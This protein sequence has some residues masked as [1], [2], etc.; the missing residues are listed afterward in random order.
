[1]TCP[2]LDQHGE[3]LDAPIPVAETVPPVIKDIEN[4]RQRLGT[5]GRDRAEIPAAIRRLVFM[6]D[7]FTCQWCG[8]RH[9]LNLRQWQRVLAEPDAEGAPFHLDHITPHAAGGC[10]HAHNLRVLCRTCNEARS[11]FATDHRARALPVVEQCTPCRTTALREL[12]EVNDWSE[13]R[14]APTVAWLRHMA[15]CGTCRL[16]SWVDHESLLQ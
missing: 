2:T 10:D 12:A 9:R 6:R 15:Y 16:A 11:N 4:A 8:A 1:M 7:E 5:P 3:R 14:I 13:M